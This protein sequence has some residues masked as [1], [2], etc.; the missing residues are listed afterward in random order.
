[1]E[2]RILGPFEVRDDA[3][4]LYTLRR[5]K[6]HVLLAGLVL[7]ANRPVP[8]ERIIDWLSGEQPPASA[9]ANLRSYVSDLR[10][11]LGDDGRDCGRDGGRIQSRSGCYLLRVDAD[12][13]D[14]DVFDGLVA[15]G[16]RAVDGEQ[17]ALAAERFTRAVGLWRSEVVLDGMALPEQLRAET[18]RLERQRMAAMESGIEARLSVG[19][20]RELV[21][22][23]AGLTRRYPLR[24]RLWQQRLL[25]LYRSG[26]R[27]DALTAYQQVREVLADELGVDPGPDLRR[28]H[29][30]MLRADPALAVS[31]PLT[32]LPSPAQLPTDL[33]TFT[34]R[35]AEVSQLLA[36]AADS[37]DRRE[38]AVVISAIDGMAGV[39]KTALAIHVAHQLASDYPDGQVFVDLHGFTEGM[40]PVDPADA[41]DRLLRSVGVS[42]EHIPSRVEEAAALWRTHLADRRML[43][44]FDN[45]VDE[46]QVRPL[47][48]G[49]PGCLVLITSR[50]GLAG[51]DDARPISLDV[52]PLDD[53]IALFVR[54]AGTDRLVAEPTEAITDVVELCGRL[55]LAIRIAAARL[56]HRPTW[57]VTHLVDRLR[58]QQHLLTELEAGQRSVTAAIDLSYHHLTADQQRMF[59]L[60]GLHPGPDFD[61]Y[62]AAAL[63]TSA[64]IRQTERLLDDLVDAHLLEQHLPGRYRFH[65]LVRLHAN[66]TCLE[67]HPEPI[68]RAA[69]TRLL[70]YYRYAATAAIDATHPDATDHRPPLPASDILVP[71]PREQRETT[72]WLEVE[73]PNLLAAARAAGKDWPSHT[74]HLSKK[75]H[76]HLYLRARYGDAVTLHTQALT[77]ARASN[78]R[79]G[80]LT[81][82]RGLGFVLVMTGKRESGADCFQRS[83]EIAREIGDRIEEMHVLC[84]IGIVH[85]AQGKYESARDCFQWSLGIARE[86]G[87]RTAE[88]Y[89]L[90]HLGMTHNTR[91][92]HK[93]AAACLEQAL[94]FALADNNR[95]GEQGALY[96]LGQIHQ[97]Q[98]RYESAR[99]CFQRSLD[100]A[101]EIGRRQGELQALHCLGMF[102]HRRGEHE[103]AIDYCL[104]ALDIASEIGNRN[105]QM[106]SLHELGNIY[107]ATGHYDRAL[108]H[109]QQALETATVLGQI[110]DQA[111]I[112]H[113]AARSY[114]ALGQYEQARVQWQQALAILDDLGVDHIEEVTAEQIRAHLAA[115]ISPKAPLY[116]SSTEMATVPRTVFR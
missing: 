12:E 55:P 107:H 106:E 7:N 102:H 85:R 59:A 72:A 45:A 93:K 48:P 24:E 26:Y 62:A 74:I 52:L 86:I 67:R 66:R 20:H 90:R 36:M 11:R 68:R 1:V 47:V 29:E 49:T 22:E 27:T 98:G 114:S 23:L 116:G 16:N 104:R 77:C 46:A 25:A 87:H 53:A 78:D 33:S 31:V 64:T 3:G 101:R 6:Q 89:A 18:A 19:Q 38:G 14:A 44:V 32:R 42:G 21:S 4:R 15:Q 51:L 13:L 112:L 58:D 92:E 97:A 40:D 84:G 43:L 113:G 80:E 70:D 81:A 111:R 60:L 57:S 73:L 39:G 82:L 108:T 79:A 41:L 96:G 37:P 17:H 88:A 50:R 91:G 69:L 63:A 71:D 103:Q 56:R 109:H 61:A 10:R 94:A 35:A 9:V 110:P 2:F 54:T 75:L 34:G 105:F 65:D 95:I 76:H 30:Q 99:D 115:L 8:V 28:L 100:I 5:R 83:L